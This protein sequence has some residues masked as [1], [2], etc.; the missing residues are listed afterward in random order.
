MPDVDWDDVVARNQ[1][2]VAFV[3]VLGYG[4]IVDDRAIAEAS[5]AK[6]LYHIFENIG[7]AFMTAMTDWN[8]GQVLG[9]SAK[10]EA[11]SFSDCFYFTCPVLGDLVAFVAYLFSENFGYF[12]G[13]YEDDV[14]CWTPF[15]RGAVAEGWCLNFLDVSLSGKLA[16]QGDFRN[17]VGP[18][19]A[20]AYRLSEKNPK[21]PGMGIVLD[22]ACEAKL[23]GEQQEKPIRHR[24][25]KWPSSA[26]YREAGGSIPCDTVNLL[27]VHRKY[28]V[29][30]GSFWEVDWFSGV[31]RGRHSSCVGFLDKTHRQFEDATK[32]YLR[33][34]E[35]AYKAALLRNENRL[36]EEAL[37]ILRRRSC[38][39]RWFGVQ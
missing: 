19:I 12:E 16:G 10:I 5:K 3:D 37:G 14:D 11:V 23:V 21:L 24:V 9:A 32:H 15:L 18:A 30:G 39:H 20:K 13:V 33:T 2:Y 27:P 17:P 4:S 6:R 7:Q 34:V 29:D 38:R 8:T 35:L 26:A 25:V 28:C 1:K 22:P 31:I 36:A